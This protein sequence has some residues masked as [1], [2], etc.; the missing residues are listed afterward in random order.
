MENKAIPVYTSNIPEAYWKW[1]N[2]LK[3]DNPYITMEIVRGKVS[4]VRTRTVV[5]DETSIKGVEY[6]KLIRD[7]NGCFLER[8]YIPQYH[9]QENIVTS[10]A[11]S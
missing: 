6:A 11:T 10:P 1:Y 2:K 7:S 3:E 5:D 4:V 9:P 8:T